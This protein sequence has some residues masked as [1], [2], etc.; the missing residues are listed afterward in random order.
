MAYYHDL[1]TEQSWQEL[2]KLQKKV[3]FILI[4]GWA[5]YLYTKTLKSK[6]IDILIDYDQLPVLEKD[7]VLSKN[8]RLKKY[9][10]RRDAVEIDIYLPHFSE[11]GIPVAH[12]MKQTRLHEGFQVIDPEFLLVLKLYTLSQRGRSPKGKKDFIDI[13]ALF[14]LPQISGKKIRQLLQD[15][16]LDKVWNNFLEFLGEHHEVPELNLNRH[17]FSKVKKKVTL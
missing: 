1:I 4:G 11:L 14:Q 6:D 16:R 13:M 12:L 17:Q 7:Y 8:D 9:E 5:T 10:A 15:H 3:R 2:Q